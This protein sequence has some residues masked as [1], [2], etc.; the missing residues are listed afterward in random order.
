M[1]INSYKE[2]TFLKKDYIFYFGEFFNNV[3]KEFRNIFG[4]RPLDDLSKGELALYDAINSLPCPVKVLRLKIDK[5][6]Y[7]DAKSNVYH[8]VWYKLSRIGKFSMTYLGEIN[9]SEIEKNKKVRKEFNLDDSLLKELKNFRIVS[10]GNTGPWYWVQ[11]IPYDILKNPKKL[12]ID[13]IDS[14]WIQ[15]SEKISKQFSREIDF[16]SKYNI[17]SDTMLS[18]KELLKKDKTLNV[19]PNINTKNLQK[20]ISKIQLIPKVP[21][22]VRQVF[23]AAKR[24]HVFGYFEYYFFTIS[25]HYAYLALESALRNRYNEIYGK[26]KN[27]I[28][29]K[30]IIGKLVGKEIITKRDEKSYDIGA[31]LRNI[32]SHLTD[33]PIMMPRSSVLKSVA[34]EINQ[35]YDV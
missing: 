13:F 30:T 16:K 7:K 10:Y 25:Q 28:G 1:T 20:S 15:F 35:L 31:R 9:I 6:K 22:S 5:I 34:Y 26:P 27:F 18:L 12:V 24:L 3:K 17:P 11:V 33:P 8:L 14:L 19:F 32:F 29:L 21:K 4:S 23:N 2:Q